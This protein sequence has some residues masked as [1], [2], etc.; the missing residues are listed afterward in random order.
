MPGLVYGPGDTSQMG[1]QLRVAMNGKLPYLSFPTLG[2]NAVHVA[3]SSTGSCWHSIV[4]A[5]GRRTC[6]E[7]RSRGH[8]T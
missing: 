1:S 2:I 8:A 7:A 4:A 5:S 3:T 6:W